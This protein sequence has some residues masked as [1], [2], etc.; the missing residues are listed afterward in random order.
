MDFPVATEGENE[1]AAKDGKVDFGKYMRTVKQTAK[2]FRSDVNSGAKKISD[3]SKKGPDLFDLNYFKKP[4]P[5]RRN[6]KKVFDF[7]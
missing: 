3:G 7:R 5:K 4:R 1:M 2:Q 6:K